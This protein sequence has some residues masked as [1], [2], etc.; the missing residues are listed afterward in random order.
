MK[1]RLSSLL[2][3]AAAACVATACGPAAVD[4]PEVSLARGTVNSGTGM[5]VSAYPDASHAG[6]EVL[7]AGG[8]AVDAA[9]ATGLVLAV[10]HP[11]A[12]NIGGA[13]SW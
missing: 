11:T 6:A 13:A 2:I 7:R 3:A 4:S 8:N 5:V 12:G 9:I 1:H 10:T